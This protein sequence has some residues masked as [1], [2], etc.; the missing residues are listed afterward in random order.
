MHNQNQLFKTMTL[1]PNIHP[2]RWGRSIL[3]TRIA[4]EHLFRT[5][6][7]FKIPQSIL[8]APIALHR[9]TPL[10]SEG[11]GANSFLVTMWPLF[12]P[13]K[14]PVLGCFGAISPL[15]STQQ[16]QRQC[17][18]MQIYSEEDRNNQDKDR[19]F[20]P[21]N[22]RIIHPLIHSEPNSAVNKRLRASECRETCTKNHLDD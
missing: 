19:N 9:L 3:I 21:I 6:N 1:P 20:Q 14:R 5:S 7:Q 13:T 2:K 16:I 12:N 18:A 11:R 10:R 15:Q 22:Y 8:K 17:I 4:Q